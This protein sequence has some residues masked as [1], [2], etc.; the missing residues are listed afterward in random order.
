MSDQTIVAEADSTTWP[1]R[2]PMRSPSPS[3][4]SVDTVSLNADEDDPTVPDSTTNDD[5]TPDLEILSPSVLDGNILYMYYIITNL[6]LLFTNIL[7][8]FTEDF[9]LALDVND[10]GAAF[11]DGEDGHG[12]EAPMDVPEFYNPWDPDPEFAINEGKIHISIPIILFHY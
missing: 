4:W 5:E 11:A 10:D 12:E 2:S 9:W 7:H 6:C 8:F 3:A 1:F